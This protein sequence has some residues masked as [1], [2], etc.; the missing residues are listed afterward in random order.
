MP[1][2]IAASTIVAQ[3]F[4]FME[5]SPISSFDDD[6]E[7]AQAAAEQYPTALAICL[8]AADWA[9][10]STL[11]FLPQA[12]LDPVQAIDPDLPYVFSLP[13]GCS[14]IQEVGDG[15]MRWRRDLLGLRADDPGP[16]RIRYTAEITNE[17]ALPANFR[18]AVA[19]QLALLL[20]PRWLTTQ[21]K[22]Q[23]LQQQAE[24]ALKTAM[25]QDARNASQARYD[26]LE[27]QGDWA[28]DA[29]R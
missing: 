26:G 15:D 4:R 27:D 5:A 21:S 8:E 25:R 19:L 14:R 2:P 10:A 18:L 22:I 11:A 12:V 24:V 28:R 9:F 3:A 17:A 1:T 6:S 13:A 20:A 23:G 29:I 7:Q 16:L